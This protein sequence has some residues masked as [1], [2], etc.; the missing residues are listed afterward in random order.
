MLKI[1]TLFWCI[2]LKNIRV[3]LHIKSQNDIKL[4]IKSHSGTYLM[5]K[6][7]PINVQKKKTTVS[8]PLR[9]LWKIRQNCGKFKKIDEFS[10]IS[11][12]VLKQSEYY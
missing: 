2:N 7:A 3:K 10:T 11:V 6:N 12:V 9:K 5:C 8:A 4:H 1:Y